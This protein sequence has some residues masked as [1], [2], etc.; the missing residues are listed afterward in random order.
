MTEPGFEQVDAV[1]VMFHDQAFVPLKA[2]GLDRCASV[3]LGL[4]M[5]RTSVAHGT[6]YE[7]V[8]TDRFSEQSLRNAVELAS[9]M[10]GSDA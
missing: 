5:V 10:T 6:G 4:N 3:T 7:L 2:R 8:G 1:V 9:R